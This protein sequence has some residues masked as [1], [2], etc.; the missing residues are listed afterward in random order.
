MIRK[1]RHSEVIESFNLD[2]EVDLNDLCNLGWFSN[3]YFQNG[4]VSQ[5]NC[6]G[7][8]SD[9]SEIELKASV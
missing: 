6:G 5:S 3:R 4:A 1:E 9:Q 7:C 2:G 8:D